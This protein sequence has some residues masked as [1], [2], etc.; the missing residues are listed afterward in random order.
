V[1]VARGGERRG[2]RH[3][4]LRRGGRCVREGRGGLGWG[5]GPHR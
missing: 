4:R 2:G 3:A 1:E 5:S